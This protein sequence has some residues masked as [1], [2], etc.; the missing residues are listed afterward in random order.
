[1]VQTNEEQR[2]GQNHWLHIFNEKLILNELLAKTSE[3]VKVIANSGTEPYSDTSLSLVTC[4][5]ST[6]TGFSFS[7]EKQFSK[8]GKNTEIISVISDLAMP[9]IFFCIILFKKTLPV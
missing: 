3:K 5:I 8:T 6:E 4:R 1:M 7:T 9:V 2:K